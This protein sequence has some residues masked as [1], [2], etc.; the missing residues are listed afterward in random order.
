MAGVSRS[1]TGITPLLLG[2]TMIVR[3]PVRLFHP[4]AELLLQFPIPRR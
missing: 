2:C 4:D 1:S 3:D